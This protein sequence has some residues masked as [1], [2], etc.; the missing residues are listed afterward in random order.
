MI[1]RMIDLPFL[2][3]NTCHCFMRCMVVLAVVD[4]CLYLYCVSG[5]QHWLWLQ[6][7]QNTVFFLILLA[8]YMKIRL[9]EN[10]G[11]KSRLQSL[12]LQHILDR[13]PVYCANNIPELF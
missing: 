2:P 6:V 7:F 4:R 5:T 9:R 10:L 11:E 3:N 8:K 12:M 13:A 1:L